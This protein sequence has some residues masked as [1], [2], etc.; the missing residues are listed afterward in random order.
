[1]APDLV[2][3]TEMVKQIKFLWFNCI[4]ITQFV[5]LVQMQWVR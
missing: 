1:M 2:W 3:L 4:P 5:H